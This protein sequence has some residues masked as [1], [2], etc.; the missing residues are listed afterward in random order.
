MIEYTTPSHDFETLKKIARKY[1]LPETHIVPVLMW[2]LFLKHSLL[3]RKI[4]CLPSTRTLKLLARFL[5][6]NPDASIQTLVETHYALY[7]QKLDTTFKTEEHDASCFKPENYTAPV[8]NDT[9][10]SEAT[11]TLLWHSLGF[12]QSLRIPT[13]LPH[14][15]TEFCSEKHPFRELALHY[16]LQTAGHFN[17]QEP[18]SLAKA[19][20]LLHKLPC[21]PRFELD[22]KLRDPQTAA[23]TFRTISSFWQGNTAS[24]PQQSD[25][26]PLMIESKTPE[27][28]AAAISESRAIQIL[29]QHPGKSAAVVVALVLL[30]LLITY[31]LKLSQTTHSETTGP[32]NDPFVS[33]R[34][35]TSP[36]IQRGGSDDSKN[37]GVIFGIIVGSLA[38]FYFLKKYC[39]NPLQ[40]D[41]NSIE[42]GPAPLNNRLVRPKTE[43]SQ[44]SKNTAKSSASFLLTEY[45]EG[46]SPLTYWMDVHTRIDFNGIS[47]NRSTYEL[48]PISVQAKQVPNTRQLWEQQKD[49]M[50]YG[51]FVLNTYYWTFIPGHGK[52]WRLPGVLS[53]NQTLSHYTLS[54][55]ATSLLFFRDQTTR[56][57][58]VTC[59]GEVPAVFSLEIMG[60][61][62]GNPVANDWMEQKVPQNTAARLNESLKQ[63]IQRYLPSIALG[64]K[65]TDS[66]DEKIK[67]LVAYGS[68]FTPGELKGPYDFHANLLIERKGSCDHRSWAV[69]ALGLYYGVEVVKIITQGHAIPGFRT[70]TGD[71]IAFETGGVPVTTQLEKSNFSLFEQLPSL[72]TEETFS[73]A[74]HAHLEKIH[75]VLLA[76]SQNHLSPSYPDFKPLLALLESGKLHNWVPDK[77]FFEKITNS[78]LINSSVQHV[79]RMVFAM[80]S[81]HFLGKPEYLLGLQKAWLGPNE[82]NPY[83]Q[84][85]MSRPL[86]PHPFKLKRPV[87][88]IPDAIPFLLQAQINGVPLRYTLAQTRLVQKSQ[89]HGG[90]INMNRF[91]QRKADFFSTPQGKMLI[92]KPIVVLCEMDKR[93]LPEFFEALWKTV[94]LK[95]GNLIFLTAYGRFEPNS[96]TDLYD[97]LAFFHENPSPDIDQYW[98]YELNIPLPKHCLILTTDEIHGGLSNGF[99]G[100]VKNFSRQF[101]VPHYPFFS[102]SD[103]AHQEISELNDRICAAVEAYLADPTQLDLSFAEHRRLINNQLK[104]M[105][106]VITFITRYFNEN[107]P[108]TR[109][110]C[111]DHIKTDAHSLLH[112]EHPS[113]L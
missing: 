37:L 109:L 105:E 92:D 40:S 77:L 76:N 45:Y 110:I 51:S 99:S 10:Y 23:Q 29:K 8:S 27:T 1:K 17:A 71:I 88:P 95:K 18:A 62:M 7:L 20:Q 3:C 68:S 19:E 39:P 55:P 32:T 107:I 9:T 50:Y 82:L 81:E 59:K 26:S 83:I 106:I 111:P 96:L 21:F 31:F 75:Q 79:V 38:L 87:K 72:H 61:R 67:K 52:M 11:K 6:S 13:C 101:K 34:T 4:H 80:Y 102:V 2:H 25:L 84:S 112:F 104:T 44:L 48:M 108:L 49:K 12:S 14:L 46:I 5:K 74:L 70:K 36:S 100:M 22:S 98:H 53:T 33:N 89:M 65:D 60:P 41:L 15:N 103:L 66:T 58:F 64:I 69:L 97:G 42:S 56:A 78:A 93:C 90:S 47:K 63:T 43:P 113:A 57:I 73:T 16:L 28:T 35:L 30:G 86:R 54:A 85:L 91:V 94:G 24:P